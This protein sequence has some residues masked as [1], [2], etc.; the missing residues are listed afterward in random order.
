MTKNPVRRLGCGNENQIRSHPFFKDLDWVALEQRKV[1][2]P[3]RPKVVYFVYIYLQKCVL[4]RMFSKLFFSAI[5][6][7]HL[8]L[9]PSLLKKSPSLHPFQMTSFVAST[10]RSLLDSRSSTEFSDRSGK[11]VKIVFFLTHQCIPS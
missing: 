5:L 8:T 9:T 3:F 10:K 11:F 7:T 6:V 2:P 1:E 4:F